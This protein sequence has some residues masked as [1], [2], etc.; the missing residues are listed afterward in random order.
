MKE[1]VATRL[2]LWNLIRMAEHIDS[3]VNTPQ[4]EH[5]KHLR[6]PLTCVISEAYSA[7]R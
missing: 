2:L 6:N 4:T 5:S 3:T 1:F 7:I